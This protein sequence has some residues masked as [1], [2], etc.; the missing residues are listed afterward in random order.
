MRGEAQPGFSPRVIE[1]SGSSSL[2]RRRYRTFITGR[3]FVLILLAAS[4]ACSS[5]QDDCREVILPSGDLARVCGDASAS[6]SSGVDSGDGSGCANTYSKRLCEPGCLGMSCVAWPPDP[7]DSPFAGTRPAQIVGEGESCN[8]L[9]GDPAAR[10][11][12]VGLYCDNATVQAISDA[13]FAYS[14]ICAPMMGGM[15][16][17]Q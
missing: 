6:P 2:D 12:A 16:P 15:C 10:A 8:S 4:L 5:T 3:W 11:C 13:G 7:C 1:R 9:L 17:V 14:G